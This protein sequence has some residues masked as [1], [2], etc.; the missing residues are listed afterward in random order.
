MQINRLIL[1]TSRLK[2]QLEFYTQKLG[3]EPV[4]I[5]GNEFA[6]RA[7]HSELHFQEMTTTDIHLYHVAFNVTENGF[8]LAKEWLITRNI[9]PLV[10]DNHS[11]FVFEDWN[12]EAIYFRDAD[13]NIIEFITRHNL[14]N[15]TNNTVF[16]KEDIVCISEA[17]IVVEDVSS[18]VSHWIQQ[19]NIGLWREAGE[20]FKAVGGED[21]LLIVVKKNRAWFP[22]A[23]TAQQQPMTLYSSDLRS[24]L[25]YG[26]YRFESC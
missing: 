25:N 2:D 17:G 20:D 9:F 18:F 15:R 7:G 8:K 5:Q 16:Q 24:T 12:A 6:V 4:F 22:T 14:A 23:I 11:Q 19:T 3:L 13:E 10:K 21:G 26:H 1:Q